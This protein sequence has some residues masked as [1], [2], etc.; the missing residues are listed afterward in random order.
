MQLNP[1]VDGQAG[2]GAP[3]GGESLPGD[4]QNIVSKADDD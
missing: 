4:G 2:D 3:N 1:F